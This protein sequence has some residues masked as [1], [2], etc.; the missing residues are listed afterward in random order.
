MVTGPV[1]PSTYSGSKKPTILGSRS[2]VV[3]V[4]VGIDDVGGFSGSV[5]NDFSLAFL[6]LFFSSVFNSYIARRLS[7][8]LNFTSI[9]IIIAII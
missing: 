8:L 7:R 2:V 9:R 4:E 3:R 1:V 6:P 5:G